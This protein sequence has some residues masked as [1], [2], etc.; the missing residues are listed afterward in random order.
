MDQIKQQILEQVPIYNSAEVA[1]Q[2][3]TPFLHLVEERQGFRVYDKAIQAALNACQCVRIPDLG[4]IIYLENPLILSSGCKLSVSKTQ[5]ISNISGSAHCLIRNRHIENGYAAY[6]Q[7]KDPDTD[8]VIEGG[9]W[10]GACHDRSIRFGVGGSEY[11]EG[12]RSI[13]LFSNVEQIVIK[14]ATFCNGGSN[15]AVQLSNASGFHISGL[16]FIRF[17][18]DGVHM[19]GPLSY[20]E[21]CHLSGRDMGDDMVALNAWDW[22]T[23]AVTFGTIAYVYVHD[24]ES[25]NNEFRLLPGRKVYPAGDVDCDIH[26]CIIENLSGIYTFK[27]YCQPNF[28]NA[29]DKTSHDISGAVGNIYQ[30]YF[31]NILINEKRNTGF[32]EIP[33]K[34]IFEVC[35]D[36]H[37]IYMEDIHI[38][39]TKEEFQRNDMH[40]MNVGPLS[41]VWKNN[42]EN[43]ED[44]SELFDPNAVCC[45][46]DLHLRNINFRGQKEMC[47]EELVHEVHMTVNQEYPRTTPKG[48]IG[49]GTVKRVS[50][51]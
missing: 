19:N 41:A 13:M 26:H 15:Y 25:H 46:T 22:D 7:H 23:S 48:G 17:G 10:D 40:F 3:I 36:C 49:Y 31:R 33:V 24:N 21:V 11:V 2:E 29:V 9:I 35:A 1:W 32:S 42:S 16:H 37:D 4:E 12:A 18:R 44:W 45:M 43:P 51:E 8:L 5:R 27:M 38:Q 39:F 47:S 50:V 30:V 28:R 20:G 14:D 6:V 34:S